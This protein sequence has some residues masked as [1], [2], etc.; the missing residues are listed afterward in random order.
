MTS[1]I[2]SINPSAYGLALGRI[3]TINSSAMSVKRMSINTDILG[4]NP[5]FV[6]SGSGTSQ[7]LTGV[8]SG[9]T[10]NIT[11]VIANTQSNFAGDNANVSAQVIAANGSV[12]GLSV[13][14][15]GIGYNNTEIATFTS[16]DGSKIGTARTVL[17]HQGYGTGYYTST[18]GF[19]D[20]DKYIQDGFFY[21]NF[22][23]Q[24]Q[25]SLSVD[26]YYNMVKDVAHTAGTAL[27][28]AVIKKSYVS[29]PL[30]ITST[31]LY[32]N[33]LNTSQIIQ[34]GPITG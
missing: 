7:L 15:S 18:R 6:I 31:V 32:A 4:V 26:K 23:Y 20:S 5:D 21:Q 33:T 14:S 28:G 3:R 29:T 13:I 22:A 27:Y 19:L 16:Q 25:S 30:N 34:T 11:L 17:G 9:A 12:T 10:A 24:I 1:S 8:T 2:T